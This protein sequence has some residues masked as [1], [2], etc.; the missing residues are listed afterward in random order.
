MQKWLKDK[1]IP[2]DGKM[3]KSKLYEIIELKK[4][5]PVHKTDEFLRGKGHDVFRLPPYHCEFN[6]IEMVLEDVKGYVGRENNTFK[7]N[8]IKDLIIKGFKTITPEKWTNFCNHVENKIEPQYLL[9]MTE[10]ISE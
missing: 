5:E 9:N 4:P 7:T 10:F 2:F 1:K 6:P 8:D 3:K